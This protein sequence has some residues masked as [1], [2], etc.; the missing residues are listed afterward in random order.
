MSGRWPRRTAGFAALV[1]VVAM[2]GPRAALAGPQAGEDIDTLTGQAQPDTDPVFTAQQPFGLSVQRRAGC[3]PPSGSP[4]PVPSNPLP[5]GFPTCDVLLVADPVNYLVR[6]ITASDL[7]PAENVGAGDA[8][9]GTETGADAAASQLSGPYAASGDAGGLYVADTFANQVRFVDALGHI[10]LVAGSADGSLGFSGDGGPA[11][12]ALL[13]QPFGIARDG[14]RGVTYVADTLNNRVRAI[15]GDGRITTVVGTGVPGLGGDGPGTATQLDGPRGLALDGDGGLLIA[16]AGNSVVRR[17]D[18]GSGLVTRIAGDGTAGFSGDGGPAR[19]ARL[20]EPSGVAV[21]PKDGTIY[22][23]DTDNHRVRSVRGTAIDTVVGTGVAG[24]SPNGTTA[25]AARLSFPFSVAVLSDGHLIVGDTGNSLVR[26]VDASKI[27]TLAGTGTP[28]SSLPRDQLSGPTAAIVPA[29]TRGLA[30]VFCNVVEVASLG[31][32]VLVLDTFN[33]G[34]R[35]LCAPGDR[36]LFQLLG[37][38][39]PGNGP[40]GPFG[41]EGPVTRLAYPMGL[42][43]GGPRA[44]I[45]VADTFNDV[46]RL[47]DPN[48][49]VLAVRTFAGTG[50]PGFAGDGGPAAQAQLDHPQGVA[51]DARGN[52][53]IADTYNDR[54]RKVDTAGVITTIAGTGV[55]G[56]DGD[57]GPATSARLYFPAGVAVDGAD[58]ANVF[59]T[60]TF[61]HRVRRID[62]TTGVITTIAGSG[63]AGFADG[64]AAAAQFDRPW[65]IAVDTTPAPVGPVVYVTDELNHRVRTISAGAVGTM[66]GTGARGFL[67]DRGPAAAAR[68]NAPR[69]VAALDAQGTLLVADSFNNRVRRIGEGAL[70]AADLDFGGVRTVSQPPAN[71]ATATFVVRNT[72]TGFLRITAAEFQGSTAFTRNATSTGSADCLVNG[73]LRPLDSC[74]LGVFFEPAEPGRHDGSVVFVTDGAPGVT[75]HMTGNGLQP[76]LGPLPASLSFGFNLG[77]THRVTLTNTG[78][79]PLDGTVALPAGP[80]HLGSAT[81]HN[82]CG[83]PAFHVAVGASCDLDVTYDCSSG[84]RQLTLTTDDAPEPQTVTRQIELD[85]FTCVG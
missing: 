50:K 35:G 62:G 71:P 58:P 19:A 28:S 42:A 11:A 66:T 34:L 77:T 26:A 56:G 29:D 64:P 65:G 4:A 73:G 51:V 48:P 46:V 13:D 33:H 43:A 72:G 36:F 22:I 70:T 30:S 20:A 18:P 84:T 81:N 2:L 63:Q 68:V 69:G 40:D 5:F 59:V 8:G 24:T 3:T 52:L 27:F 83:I 76:A 85:G 25:T 49:G 16:D 14:A 45:F 75:A 17:Y 53:Y 9:K 31:S 12:A 37:D 74:L 61:S 60:D 38:G 82:E 78:T 21:D 44:G 32:I 54:I 55:S 23:A 41:T 6:R 67:G 39:R 7:G 80:F 15:A 1:L 79:W 10:H 47:V 57:N